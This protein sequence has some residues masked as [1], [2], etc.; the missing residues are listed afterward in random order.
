M[1]AAYSPGL[2]GVTAGISAISEVDAERN[3]LTYRGYDIH[4]L[5]EHCSFDEVAYLLLY[6]KLP[7]QSQFD[8]FMREVGESRAVPP[9]IYDLYRGF[10]GDAHPM[11]TLKAAVSV[12]AMFDPASGETTHEANLK[13][14]VRL[15][16]RIPNLVVNGYRI[17]HGQEPIPPDTQLCHNANFFHMLFGEVETGFKGKAFNVIQILYAEHGFNAST[18]AARVTVSTLSDIYSG[19]VSA[20]GTLKGPL[21]GGANEAAMQMLLE[22]GEPARAEA[23]VLDALAQRRKIMG[24]GHREYKKGDERARIAKRYM[25]ELGTRLNQTRWEEISQIVEDV[26]MEKKGLYP[27]LDFPVAG[28]YYLMGIPIP[29]YTPIFVMSRIT[30]WCAHII[31]QLDNNRIIRP[32]SEYNG[33][34]GLKFVPLAERTGE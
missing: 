30:G 32:H 18:F 31:E 27:N 7:T 15:Y 1:S 9:E 22:I 20:I 21:H 14:A 24:F 8:E 12:L 4:D 19:I 33:P 16:A 17:M 11:D 3:S 10:P 28:A 29:L 34:R 5:V 2:E 6:G 23:W 26:M 25:M 13:R